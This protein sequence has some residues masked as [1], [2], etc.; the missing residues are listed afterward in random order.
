M[1]SFPQKLEAA[2]GPTNVSR[3]YIQASKLG[4]ALMLI[5]KTILCINCSCVK[6][7]L[8][9]AKEPDHIKEMHRP[10]GVYL[11]LQKDQFSS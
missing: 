5:W 2:C 1:K 10:A 6:E 3:T 11:K 7:Y 9:H 4:L 8:Y